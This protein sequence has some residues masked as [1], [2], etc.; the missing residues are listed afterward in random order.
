MKFLGFVGP[1]YKL[2]SVNYDCQR[3]INLYAEVDESG[4]GKEQQVA[5]LVSTPGLLSLVSLGAGPIRGLWTASTGELFA[6]SSNT[7]Y[8]ISSSFVASSIGT[9]T[10]FSGPVSMADNGLD[11]VVVD[12][13][14]GY[15]WTFA[16]STFQQIS[17]PDFPGADQVAFQDAYF[18]FNQPDTQK[19]F[20]SEL[21]ATTFDALDIASAEGSPDLLVGLLSDHRDLWLF[22]SRSIEVWFNTNSNVDFP[23]ERIQ[24]A[25]V[26]HGCAA[27]FSIAKMN[28][29]VYWLGSDD[30]GSGMVFQATGYQPQR[31]STHAVEQAIQGY[32]TID[33]AV[34]WTY[35]ENGHHFYCL[36]FS[37]ANTTWVFD[38]TTSLWHER[39]Y[40]ND[41]QLERHR[42]NCH[43]FAYGQHIVG[44]YENGNL[45]DL[46][47]SHLTDNG[48][49]ITRE[50]V[51]PHVSSDLLNVFYSKFQLD[52]E[53]GTGIDGSGQGVDPQAMLTFSDDGGHTWSNEKWTSFGKIGETKARAIWRRLGCARDR[54]FKISIT[55]PVK[56]TIIG[57]QL[58]VGPGSN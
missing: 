36:N 24:G 17:D 27:P 55:D 51:T 3:C 52:I 20:I 58:D 47:S 2:N 10:T 15:V 41:G 37:S 23:F 49:A 1:S 16:S 46:K 6:V 13:T 26:E 18:I 54:V 50:R 44:D 5:A 28:N 45:Y 11:L 30:K 42:A 25:F 7:L 40:T 33:D 9:L 22:G 56:V 53:T 43:A 4:R 21:N 48:A 31:I 38:T 8:K 14:Y 39:V 19:F 12:G 29:T 57:A 32:S 34:A 35:Q